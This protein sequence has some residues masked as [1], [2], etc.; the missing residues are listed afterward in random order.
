MVLVSLVLFLM[1]P[2]W[3]TMVIRWRPRAPLRHKNCESD[4]CWSFDWIWWSM[5]VIEFWTWWSES[6]LKVMVVKSFES[7]LLHCWSKWLTWSCKTHPHPQIAGYRPGKVQQNDHMSHLSQGNTHCIDKVLK[8][9]ANQI[10]DCCCLTSG[11]WWAELVTSTWPNLTSE[12]PCLTTL[13]R[14]IPSIILTTLCRCIPSII[15]WL[16]DVS[17]RPWQASTSWVW[18]S[19]HP[20]DSK[21][22]ILD[23]A[24]KPLGDHI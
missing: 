13:C 12:R 6:W 4:G 18:I 8:N 14:C 11:M 2:H 22:H 24:C 21:W 9:I 1:K 15:F 16:T 5:N 10:C 3:Q 23:D 20:G 19:F 17:L 7:K